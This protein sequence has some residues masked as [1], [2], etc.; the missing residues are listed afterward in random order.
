MKVVVLILAILIS[1]WA[2]AVQPVFAIDGVAVR[3]FDVVAYFTQQQPVPGKLEFATQWGGVSWQFS[4]QQNL[5]QF[6][7]DPE[8]YVPQFGGFCSLTMAHGSS[9]PINPEAWAIHDGRLYLFIF[10]AARETWQMNPKQLIQRAESRWRTVT[11][12]SNR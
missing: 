10:P 5:E 4:S 6:R 3:G 1:S 7:D 8:R 11:A 2:N 12:Q 9:I